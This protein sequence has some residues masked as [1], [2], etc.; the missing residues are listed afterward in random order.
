MIEG[1]VDRKGEKQIRNEEERQKEGE[2]EKQSQRASRTAEP[3]SIS[4]HI[5]LPL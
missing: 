3:F 4:E 1:E 2:T 5:T